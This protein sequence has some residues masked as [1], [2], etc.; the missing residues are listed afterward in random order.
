[1]GKYSLMLKDI[2]EEKIIVAEDEDDA[3]QKCKLF[4]AI[5]D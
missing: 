4:K 3:S 1:M 5:L 2:A